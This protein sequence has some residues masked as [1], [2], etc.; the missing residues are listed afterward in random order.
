MS[1]FLD[2]SG[3]GCLQFAELTLA[4]VLSALVGVGRETR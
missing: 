3:Q 4:F 2:C 1:G